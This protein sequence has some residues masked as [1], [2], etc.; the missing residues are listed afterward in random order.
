MRWGKN[1]AVPIGNFKNPHEC[2]NWDRIDSWSRERSV[3]M[4][5][6]GMLVHPVLGENLLLPDFTGIDLNCEGESFPNG[7]AE[8]R[9]GVAVEDV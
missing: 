7:L 3:D 4:F 1:Q 6:P 5:A 9:I 8:I 2:V